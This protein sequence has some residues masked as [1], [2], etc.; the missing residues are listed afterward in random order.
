MDGDGEGVGKRW[1]GVRRRW[2]VIGR[3]QGG[4]GW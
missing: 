3:G 2:A 1:G 4:D